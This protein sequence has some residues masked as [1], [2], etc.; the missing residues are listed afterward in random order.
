M[1]QFNHESNMIIH[2]SSSV[3]LELDGPFIDTNASIRNKLSPRG[4]I[5]SKKPL[6][7]I[8]TVDYMSKL[9]L[10]EDNGVSMANLLHLRYD[11][12]A[13][14]GKKNNPFESKSALFPSIIGS[15]KPSLNIKS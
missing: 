4:S 10:Y 7:N 9:A 13:G 2:D 8:K 12:A 5:K 3:A 6:D 1:R 11:S 15:Y 14:D